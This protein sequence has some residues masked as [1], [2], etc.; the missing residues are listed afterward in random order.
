MRPSRQLA[1]ASAV[2]L[3][4]A[5]HAMGAAG[6]GSG[7][8][9]GGGGAGGG[10][11]SS[12]GSGSYGT[13][14]GD[15]RVVL[16]IFAIVI[17]IVILSALKQRRLRRKMAGM[18]DPAVAER[19]DRQ[20]EAARRER[21]EEIVGKS[22]VAAEDDPMFA[23]DRVVPE[24][25]ALFRAVQ[26]AWDA[27]DENRLRQ[28][29]GEDLM[30]EWSLRLADFARKGWHNR[31][32]V[33]GAVRIEYM[34]ITNLAG[35]AEDRVVV[36]VSALTDDYVVERDG[37][38]VHLDGMTDRRAAIREY[39]TL[40][41]REGRWT[42]VSIEQELEGDHHLRAPI[43]PEPAE[44]PR[45][46]DQALV[47]A[48][49]EARIDDARIADLADLDFDG[50]ALTAARDMSLVDR[51]FDPGVIEASAR[52]LVAAW[53][54]AVDGDDG[55]LLAVADLDA[56]RDMLHPED[57]VARTRLV[58]RGP[59][60]QGIHVVAVD[61]SRIPALVTVTADIEGVWFIENR[62]TTDVVAGD[63]DRAQPFTRTWTLALSDIPDTPWRAVRTGAPARS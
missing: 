40:A 6:S 4:G 16:V 24:A 25:E 42:L 45:M 52:R 57:P 11:S 32:W 35:T 49:S 37:D 53:A 15:P 13:G 23:A 55:P 54:E 48:A 62:D 18:R 51:R 61:A 38:A 36:R 5:T 10:F 17:V 2:L 63:R 44:D 58:V 47:E 8:Y 28:L 29:V 12:G 60:I 43:V 19:R 27:R 50:S 33:H 22:H 20:T 9:G 7:S 46:S 41:P 59:R 56:V 3:A 34:G 1:S 31:V 14:S 30:R 26:A 21:V 39:W